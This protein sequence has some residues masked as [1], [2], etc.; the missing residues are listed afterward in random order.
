ME[1]RRIMGKRGRITIPYAM[2]QLA[3]FRYND[4][5]AFEYNDSIGSVV[6]HKEELCDGCV[7]FMDEEDKLGEKSRKMLEKFDTIPDDEQIPLLDALIAR[8][9]RN[10]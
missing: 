5:I 1:I 7:N 4:V 10:S 9:Q 8:C 6:V 3:G 2:R